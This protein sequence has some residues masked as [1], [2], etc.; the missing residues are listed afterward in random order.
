MKR[1][2]S[3]KGLVRHRISA[4]VLPGFYNKFAAAVKILGLSQQDMIVQALEAEFSRVDLRKQC[5]LLTNANAALTEKKERLL[6]E[7]NDFRSALAATRERLSVVEGDRDMM[8]S[9]RD[10]LKVARDCFK[11]KYE[12]GVSD[13]AVVKAKL[14][15]YQGQGFWG[16]LLGRLP[17]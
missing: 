7:R 2:G 10:E 9:Q 16:R 8:L 4:R 17:Y 5:Q 11:A 3:G 6:K 14:V 13:L 12:A 15:A 1:K